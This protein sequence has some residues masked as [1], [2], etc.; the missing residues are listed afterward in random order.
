MDIDETVDRYNCI[1][2]KGSIKLTISKYKGLM[3]PCTFAENYLER[4]RLEQCTTEG[5]PM[6]CGHDW[7]TEQIEK[8]LCHGP[9]K[10]AQS[11]EAA[12]F[13][14]K[15]RE[16]ETKNGYAKVITYGES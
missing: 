5:C 11:K 16:E 12:T 6:D 14:H 9:H 10:S 7:T 1:P 15:E 3:W 2:N 4:N 8:A 13:I